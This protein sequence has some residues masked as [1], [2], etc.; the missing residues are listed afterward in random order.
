MSI[1]LIHENLT[2]PMSLNSVNFKKYIKSLT[3]DLLHSFGVDTGNIRINTKIDDD[4]IMG[5]ETAIPCGLIINE[6]ISNALKHA[7]PQGEGEIYLELSKKDNGKYL[8]KI[9]D[10]GKPFPDEFEI[11]N[12]DTLGIETY[13]HLA[14]QLDGELTINW[15]NKEFLIEFNDLNMWSGS[16]VKSRILLLKM[17]QKSQWALNK[18]WKNWIIR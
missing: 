6:L 1:A 10:N 12:T 14:K 7:F 15:E 5:I 18:N 17:K 9:K 8:L 13:Q 2:N 3:D 16:M 11:K 4:V